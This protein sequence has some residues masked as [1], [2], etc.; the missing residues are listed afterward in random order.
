M[1]DKV[2]KM[3]DIIKRRRRNMKKYQKTSFV[4]GMLIC[5]AGAGLMFDR[6]ILGETTKNISTLL[7]ITG[8]CLIATQRRAMN[9]GGE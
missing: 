2:N 7:G 9:N 1:L 3:L 5:L 6:A 4:L 8:I